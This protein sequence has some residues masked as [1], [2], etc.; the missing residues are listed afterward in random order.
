MT[1]FLIVAAM[2]FVLSTVAKTLCAGWW[3]WAR[4]SS[5]ARIPAGG[6]VVARSGS[7]KKNVLP[8]PAVLSA[9]IFPPCASTID[10]AM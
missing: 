3:E 8:C 10:R 1:L 9:Q 6:Y 7:V 5:P 2:L 4:R